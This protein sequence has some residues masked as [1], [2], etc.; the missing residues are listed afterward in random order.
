MFAAL[1]VSL[2]GSDGKSGMSLFGYLKSG[3]NR[4]ITNGSVFAE[5]FKKLLGAYEIREEELSVS[6]VGPSP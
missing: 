1:L 5:E 3:D 2:G 6:C 4:D